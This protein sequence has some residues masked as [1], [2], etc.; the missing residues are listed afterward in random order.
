MW[1][2]QTRDAP[3]VRR[4]AEVDHTRAKRLHVTGSAL[5]TSTKG[6]VTRGLSSGVEPVATGCVWLEG[7]VLDVW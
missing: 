5:E 4:R 1:L 2:E 7:G 3:I 6:R